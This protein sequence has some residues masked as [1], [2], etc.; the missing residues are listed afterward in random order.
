MGNLML[1]GTEVG[2]VSTIHVAVTVAW[3]F[4]GV[5]GQR[6][7]AL[8]PHLA[9]KACHGLETFNVFFLAAYIRFSLVPEESFHGVACQ[10]IEHSV[11]HDHLAMIIRIV[12]RVQSVGIGEQDFL[13]QP[14]FYTTASPRAV[15]DAHGNI[16]YL[17]QSL[18][19]KVTASREIDGIL[20]FADLPSARHAVLWLQGILFLDGCHTDATAIAPRKG[21]LFVGTLHR[22]VPEAFE[23]HLHVRLS[24]AEPDLAD[25]HVFDSTSLAVT[26][27]GEALRV[28]GCSGCHN[29][30]FPTS[31]LLVGSSAVGLGVPGG[32]H[33]DG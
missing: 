15:D 19:K 13:G 29:L 30:Q 33:F 5:H 6:I 23:R 24:G 18:G 32:C 8:T 22:A 10:G 21:N 17:G 31:R 4:D 28:V 27:D 7:V 1:G 2:A 9:P 11:E 25:E 26:L 12:N 3:Q 16:E 14:S 20:W